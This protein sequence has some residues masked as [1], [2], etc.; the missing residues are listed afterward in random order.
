MGAAN[1]KYNFEEKL[2]SLLSGNHRN[3]EYELQ[4]GFENVPKGCY[5]QPEKK[6]AQ[7]ILGNIRQSYGFKA[8]LVSLIASF[9]EDSAQLLTLANFLRYHHMEAR[10]LYAKYS[11]SRLCVEAGVR[12]VFSESIEE[13]MPK[14]F[15]RLVAVDYRRWIQ[16]LLELLPRLDN[17]DFTKL[18][19][20]E[21]QMLN[22]FYTTV[23][24]ETIED[25]GADEVWEKFYMLCNSPV[26]LQEL[27]ELLR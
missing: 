21:Q 7:V 10:S 19:H 12:E 20:L 18:S 15:S 17:V 4:H 27:I 8:Q 13:T 26:M 6:A 22:M 11:F 1:R 23:W 9:E 5:I 14:S 16:F 2:A 25:F 24:Q 3:V